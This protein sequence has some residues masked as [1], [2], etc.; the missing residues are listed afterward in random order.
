ML[1]RWVFKNF[2]VH[3]DP[4]EA[5]HFAM[6]AIGIFGRTPLAPLCQATVGYHGGGSFRG[7]LARP[8]PGR[9]GLA[10]GQDKDAKAILGTIALGFAFTE[11]GTV[12]P[13]PQPG[14]EKPRSW[15]ITEEKALRNKM[16]FNNDGADAVADRLAELRSSKRGR[17]AVVGVNIG[18]NKWTSAQDAPKDYS[19]C[20][21]KLARYADYLVINVSS[22]NTPGLRDLQAV[23]SLREIA[24]ATR[25]ASEKAAGRRVPVLVK[26][27]PDLA[28][29]DIAEVAQMVID[30][31]LD[32]VVATNTTIAHDYGEGGVSGAPVHERAVAV[33]T[34]L[35]ALLGPDRI[36]IGVG[37]IFT[38]SDANR[39]L[40][41]GADLLE[42]LTSFVYEGPFLPG[43]LNRA[44]ARTAG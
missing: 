5:H 7:L 44:L 22:P 32:G 18:K 6:E 20:A 30:E 25:Q 35:R 17:A 29:S 8:L 39:M 15:R 42:I 11:I 37:G 36:I 34:Q 19:I 16:G 26:I 31:D 24:R 3:T 23:D 27:A 43:K 41:A 14:N 28:D 40:N 10:A 9:L 2:L 33:V 4:E 13:Q 12:T 21:Q 1:Y 38:V